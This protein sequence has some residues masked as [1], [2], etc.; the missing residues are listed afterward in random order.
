MLGWF[1][2]DEVNF[3]APRPGVDYL[4]RNAGDGVPAS[5]A[6]IVGVWL[7]TSGGESWYYFFYKGFRVFYAD[8]A[9]PTMF[10]GGGFWV[11]SGGQFDITWDWGNGRLGAKKV[12]T[13]VTVPKMNLFHSNVGGK[14]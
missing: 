6:D 12:S 10:R 11:P 13:A 3:S 5:A 9:S 4:A 7:V 1:D 14:F 8:G 2:I